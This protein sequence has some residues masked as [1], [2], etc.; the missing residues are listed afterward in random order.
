M[1]KANYGVDIRLRDF[2]K[3]PAATVR[4]MNQW[5]EDKTAGR[6]TDIVALKDVLPERRDEIKPG[7]ILLNAIYFK[8]LWA[9][10]FN[11]RTTR[12]E[13]FTL[14][15]GTRVKTRMMQKTSGDYEYMEEDTF[16]ALEMKYKGGHFSMVVF[17]PRKTDGLRDLEESLSPEKLSA[18]LSRLSKR[19]DG[20][21]VTFPRFKMES[22]LELIPALNVLGMTT[23]FGWN[24]DPRE[25]F[26]EL[27]E[28]TNEN[29]VPRTVF[30][31]EI[32]QKAWIEATEK[33]TE[34]AAATKFPLKFGFSG[35]PPQPVIFK[36]DHPFLFMIIHKQSKC[37]LF[38]GRVTNPKMN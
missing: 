8:C 4:E 24:Q 7:L 25:T 11:R 10:Q 31:S 12:D 15:D 6:I 18:W 37:I 1:I 20:V 16:Q 26:S 27:V 34:A 21:Q 35:M 28:K 19:T 22:A 2:L 14:L 32:L 36:A 38:M 3:D 33:G 17:L 23:A 30:I 29:A 13:D 5:V 9:V